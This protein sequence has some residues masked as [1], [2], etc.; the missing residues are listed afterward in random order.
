MFNNKF[1]FLFLID[2]TSL[3][4]SSYYEP[5]ISAEKIIL[6]CLIVIINVSSIMFNILY[7]LFFYALIYGINNLTKTLECRP[8]IEY[9][10]DLENEQE[11]FLY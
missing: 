2:L 6:N 3:L 4:I 10:V 5:I 7:I 11:E 8:E 9:F 1:L